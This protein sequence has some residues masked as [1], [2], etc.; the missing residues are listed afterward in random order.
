MCDGLD[1][2]NYGGQANQIISFRE[3]KRIFS[4]DC[5]CKELYNY[6]LDNL[7]NTNS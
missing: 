6:Q 4:P 1:L 2:F 3:E 5:F 7:I